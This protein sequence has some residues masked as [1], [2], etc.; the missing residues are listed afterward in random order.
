MIICFY[1]VEL[2]VNFLEFLYFERPIT[3]EWKDVMIIGIEGKQGSTSER[4][5]LVFTH[6]IEHLI[7]LLHKSI[8]GFN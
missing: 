8:P 4:V 1:V 3:I 7:G 2:M 6:H 5:G